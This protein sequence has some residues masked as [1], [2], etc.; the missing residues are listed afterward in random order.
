MALRDDV[1]NMLSLA[2]YKSKVNTQVVLT[3]V[4]L[5]LVTD[6][7]VEGEASDIS[8]RKDTGCWKVNQV[9]LKA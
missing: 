7:K 3:E 8:E 5:H 6:P 4:A 2:S 9:K 1:S